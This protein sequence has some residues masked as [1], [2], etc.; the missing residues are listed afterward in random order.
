M[1]P[2][3]I[4]LVKV[5]EWKEIYFIYNHEKGCLFSLVFES[6]FIYLKIFFLAI[7]NLNALLEQKSYNA[8]LFDQIKIRK[9]ININKCR[10]MLK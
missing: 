9:I 7:L 2:A 5:S 1:R 6:T 4:E 10:N 8:Q 3:L